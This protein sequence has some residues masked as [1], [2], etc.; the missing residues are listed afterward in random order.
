MAN[1]ATNI[2]G[3]S[4]HVAT[5]PV[6]W[7]ANGAA[8]TWKNTPKNVKIA[9]GIGAGI[10]ALTG[11]AAYMA[12]TTRG[13][14]F[15]EEDREVAQIPPMLTPQDLAQMSA[16]QMAME[17]GPAEGRGA[18]DFRNMVNAS[19]GR[20]LEGMNAAQPNLDTSFTAQQIG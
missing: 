16:P 5:R 20:S 3:K 18:Y 15:R 7:T 10:V 9:G 8:Y 19:K 1:W 14:Q 12:T 11:L 4:W 6:A 13:R 2:L 17:N